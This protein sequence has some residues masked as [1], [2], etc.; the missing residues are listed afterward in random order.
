MVSLWSTQ[1]LTRLL[2]GCEVGTTRLILIVSWVHRTLFLMG[3]SQPIFLYR[4]PGPVLASG[5]KGT[6]PTDPRPCRPQAKGL[7][8]LT[9]MQKKICH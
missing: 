6:R 8:D 3:N 4:V 5:H 1:P 7:T 9:P 2:N